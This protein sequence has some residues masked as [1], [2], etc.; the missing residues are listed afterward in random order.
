M[1][2]IIEAVDGPLSG[3]LHLADH[4]PTQDDEAP[5]EDDE[6][7]Y[8]DGLARDQ[9]D[10]DSLEDDAIAVTEYAEAP[11]DSPDEDM[12]SWLF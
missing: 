9:A 7:A 11:F 3:K 5:V 12:E 10:E 2:E 1:L 8:D 4:A 6:P